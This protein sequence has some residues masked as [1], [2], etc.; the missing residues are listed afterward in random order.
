MAAAQ[1]AFQD[2]SCAFVR[3]TNLCSAAAAS[4]AFLFVYPG[5]QTLL[6]DA[7][8]SLLTV[9]RWGEALCG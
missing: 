2:S 1:T 7:C 5:L 8:R 4:P 6:A 3:T 9:G